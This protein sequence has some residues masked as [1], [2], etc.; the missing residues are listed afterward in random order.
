MWI[1]WLVV[2]STASNTEVARLAIPVLVTYGFFGLKVLLTAVRNERLLYTAALV[3]SVVFLSVCQLQFTSMTRPL[4]MDSIQESEVLKAAAF[5]L[6]GVTDDQA[7]VAAEKPGIVGFYSA[8]STRALGV[9]SVANADF[10]VT[11]ARNVQGYDV[12]YVPSHV[13]SSVFEGSHSGVAVWRRH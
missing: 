5:W 2:A 7:T 1:V 3:L 8:R 6:R 4:M 12:V 10:V 9:D 13:D 11:T